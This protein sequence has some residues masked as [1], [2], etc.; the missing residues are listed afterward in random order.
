MPFIALH[1]TMKDL[2]ACVPDIRTRAEVTMPYKQDIVEVL[3]FDTLTRQI[4]AYHRV[5]RQD[6]NSMA[7]IP[8]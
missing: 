3:P 8:M 2:M 5:R 6:G 4:G 7:L 1:K